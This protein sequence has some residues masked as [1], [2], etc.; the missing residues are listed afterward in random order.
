MFLF[1]TAF[2]FAGSNSSETKLETACVEVTLSCGINF[3]L[4]GDTSN[5]T[6]IY[7]DDLLC[8]PF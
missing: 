7:L 3:D 1:V 5:E 8:G 4:C 2:S 6:I